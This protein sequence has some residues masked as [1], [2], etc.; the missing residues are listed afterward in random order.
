MMTN[1][2]HCSQSVVERVFESLLCHYSLCYRHIPN[3]RSHVFRCGLRTAA[4]VN[5]DFTRLGSDM[6]AWRE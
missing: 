6:A 5:S 4:L 1:L 3:A 2:N